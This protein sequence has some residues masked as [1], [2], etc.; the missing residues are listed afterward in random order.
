MLLDVG[1]RPVFV[2]RSEWVLFLLTLW[3]LSLGVSVR[4]STEINKHFSNTDRCFSICSY[5]LEAVT[6]PL[7]V[8]ADPCC[9]VLFRLDAKQEKIRQ[10]TREKLRDEL[11]S[12]LLRG[13]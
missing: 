6:P 3:T 12:P 10:R 11:S 7:F 8:T 1:N 2:G 13:N 5:T 4:F 9:C